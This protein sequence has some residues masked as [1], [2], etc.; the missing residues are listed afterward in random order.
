MV[1]DPAFVTA[2][3]GGI[4]IFH[5]TPVAEVIAEVNR[6]RSGKIILTNDALGRERFSARFRIE[7]IE[8]VIGQIEQIFGARATALP[9]RIVLLG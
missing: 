9:G 7:N 5:S 8:R 6:Y 2:W 4:V 1:A 3:Q